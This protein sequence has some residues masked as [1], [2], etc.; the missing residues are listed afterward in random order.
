MGTL[1]KLAVAGAKYD[2]PSHFDIFWKANWSKKIHVMYM[3]ID[4]PDDILFKLHREF[5][6]IYAY[7]FDANLLENRMNAI[8][9]LIQRQPSTPSSYASILIFY[10]FLT[11]VKHIE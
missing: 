11:N 9:L 7:K 6:E 4:K 5:Y 2:I 8:P 3:F 10:N 1:L